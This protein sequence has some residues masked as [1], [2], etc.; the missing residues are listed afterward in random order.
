MLEPQEEPEYSK[1]GSIAK[2]AAL[3]KMKKLKEEM[4]PRAEAVKSLIARDQN[5]YL[6][7][8]APNS[9]TN[10]EIEAE[11]KRMAARAKA[12]GQQEGVLP[13]AERDANLGK[14]LKDAPVK[15][16]LFHATN[17][18]FN[19]FRVGSYLTNDPDYAAQHGNRVMPV[20]MS[21]KN[22]KQILDED[23]RLLADRPSSLKPYIDEG[24]DALSTDAG[25]SYIILDPRK[26]KSSTG[27]RGTYDTNEL[28]ITKA[29]GGKVRM[30]DNRD[31]MFMELSNKK[32]KR[33]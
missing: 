7:D 19:D 12:S 33:K 18:D 10:P 4:T 30:T 20:H 2:M 31:A 14:F 8:V 5:R 1:G 23:F 9:L 29:K 25:G 26:V 17:N 28:D 3:A 11:I 6:A 21:A 15:E 24:Y 22:I 16:R 32:L 13:R 27:N